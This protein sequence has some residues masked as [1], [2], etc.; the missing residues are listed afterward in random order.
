M[1]TVKDLFE[2]KKLM[3]AIVE[4]IVNIPNDA[5]VGYEVWALGYTK[6]DEITKDEVLVGEFTDPDTAVG[7]AKNVSLELINEFG[8]DEPDTTTAYYSIEV[9][10]VIAD[11]DDEDGGTINIGTIYKR[12]LWIDGEYG[13]EEEAGVDEDPVVS[14]T[15][16]D[17]ELLDDGTLK[18]SCKLLKDFNKNDYVTFEFPEEAPV[19]YLTYQITSK[20]S[21]EDGDYYHCELMI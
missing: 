13:S 2:N 1:T 9:E 6:E 12:D 10:T 18:V 4:D 8:Y 3:D 5:E 19:A 16:R 11:P 20:V 7:Y 15:G 14:L 17:F 21:Y